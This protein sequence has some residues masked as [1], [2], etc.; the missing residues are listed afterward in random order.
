MEFEDGME[1]S[2]T[3]QLES[4][5]AENARLKKPLAEQMLDNALQRDV[6][7]TE[8]WCPTLNVTL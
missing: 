8:W 5:E 6:S 1:V 2:D 7:S 4:L 3:Q